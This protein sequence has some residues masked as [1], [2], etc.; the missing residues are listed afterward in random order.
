MALTLS[1]GS[2]PRPAGEGRGCNLS[3]GSTHV[4]APSALRESLTSRTPWGLS[5][6]KSTSSPAPPIT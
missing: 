2:N 3:P 6:V 1:Q 5:R 4:C